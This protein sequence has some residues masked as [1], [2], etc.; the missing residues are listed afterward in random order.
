VEK[1]TGC[2]IERPSSHHKRKTNHALYSCC[3]I[4]CIIVAN[5]SAFLIA[6]NSAFLLTD[7]SSACLH[8]NEYVTRAPRNAKLRLPDV[9]YLPSKI[10]YLLL[11]KKE[12][13]QKREQKLV[14][15]LSRNCPQIKTAATLATAFKERMENKN[16]GLLKRWIEQAVTS[17][18]RELR[19]FAKGLLGDFEAVKNAVTMPWS[20]GQVEGQINKL[21]TI[22]RQMYGRASFDLLRK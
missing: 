6:K 15:N 17:G 11:R 3:Q 1:V 10:S 4:L 12:L 18:I 8:L 22:K 9:F 19:S 7:Y 14:T 2:R 13:L 21:K 20:N 16:G 5:S